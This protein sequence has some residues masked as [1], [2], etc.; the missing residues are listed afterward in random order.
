MPTFIAMLRGINVSGQKIIKMESLRKSCEK[1]GLQEVQTY[2]QSGNIIFKTKTSLSI[3]KNIASKL[4]SMILRDFGFE[5]PVIIRTVDEMREVIKKNP[6]LKDKSV[7]LSRLYVT[8]LP[9]PVSS[10]QSK[11][12]DALYSQ[13]SGNSQPSGNVGGSGKSAKAS[14]A[15]STATDFFQLVRKEIYLYCPGGYGN[16]KLSNN[17]FE[18]ALSVSATT[19]NW[20]TVNKL[21]EIGISE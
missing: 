15:P 6:Y 13:I 5:V 12:L 20:N 19:R 3:S 2:V 9:E 18:K 14:K 16:T 17:L 1:I 11:K 4:T 21:L 8:F 10:A 7:D